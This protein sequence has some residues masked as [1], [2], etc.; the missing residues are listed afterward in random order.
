MRD[1]FNL[2]FFKNPEKTQVQFA[3]S[4]IEIGHLQVLETDG[5]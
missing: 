2:F 1:S 4:T 5:Y 3:L